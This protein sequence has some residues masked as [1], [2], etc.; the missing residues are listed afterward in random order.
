MLMMQDQ[1][2]LK[3]LAAG[4]PASNPSLSA[5]KEIKL[6]RGQFYLFYGERGN[7]NPQRNGHL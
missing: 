3:T 1:R 6:S 4:H 7:E 2:L 5:I